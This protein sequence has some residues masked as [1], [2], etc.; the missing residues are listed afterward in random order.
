MFSV[1]TE[2]LKPFLSK[3]PHQKSFCHVKYIM[4]PTFY[5]T[6]AVLFPWQNMRIPEYE[7][8]AVTYLL[9]TLRPCSLFLFFLPKSS[10]YSPLSLSLKT[11]HAMVMYLCWIHP[12]PEFSACL[13][14]SCS[15]SMTETAKPTQ[16]LCQFSHSRPKCLSIIFPAPRTKI[17]RFQ[18]T[19]N[20]Q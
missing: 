11:H 4:S 2:N 16:K 7:N 8:P 12:T 13:L 20:P 3:P 18:Y 10:H 19:L 5:Q 17:C 14:L 15:H 9:L 1:C 6:P